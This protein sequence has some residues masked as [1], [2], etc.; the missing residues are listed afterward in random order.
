MHSATTVPTNTNNLQRAAGASAGECSVLYAVLAP[1]LQPR[2]TCQQSLL[3]TVSWGG[4]QPKTIYLSAVQNSPEL[5]QNSPLAGF[6]VKTRQ[7]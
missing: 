2:C 5:L 1:C 4:T 7:L 3:V 6:S